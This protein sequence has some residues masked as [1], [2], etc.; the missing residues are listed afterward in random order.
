MDILVGN[1]SEAEAWG[2]AAG[3][4]DPKDRK[5]VAKALAN[6][7]K[8]NPSRERIVVITSGAEST[9]VATSNS[10]EIKVYPVQTL[11]NDQIVD[12]NGA[13]EAFAG[14]FIGGYVAGKTIDEA[15]EVGHKM[16]AMCVGQVCS[17]ILES[18]MSLTLSYL[19]LGGTTIQV[20]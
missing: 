18:G 9:T 12:T 13:G 20:A 19:S 16:G 8:T 15:V 2:A 17:A 5:A 6:L 10:D 7:P 1:E 14:G 4:P 3:L 11:S